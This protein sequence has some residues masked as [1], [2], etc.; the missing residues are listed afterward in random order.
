MSNELKFDEKLVE[1]LCKEL[2]L[3]YIHGWN[4]CK[5]NRP[6]GTHGPIYYDEGD[7]WIAYESKNYQQM[8]ES[9]IRDSH[10][11]NGPQ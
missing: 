2:A 9:Y 7:A 10:R 1:E 8:V 3:A 4:D 11:K 5:H 6:K